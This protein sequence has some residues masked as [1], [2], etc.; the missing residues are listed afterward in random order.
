MTD[1]RRHLVTLA[2]IQ[3]REVSWLQHGTIPR[4]MLAILAGH[5]GLGKSLWTLRLAAEL[6]HRGMNIVICSAED[7][8]EH[9]I[10]PRLQAAAADTTKV[11][12]LIPRDENGDAR[13]VGFPT[14]APLLLEAILAVEAVL[15]II[16]PVTAHID[17]DVDSHKD[18]SL[19]GALAPLSRIAEESFAAV[20]A[21][22]HLNKTSSSSDP[23]M[24]V[25]GSIG[26]PGAARSAL[27]I[28]RD[29]DDPD[30]DRGSRRVL[31][32]FKC[33]V[34][35]LQ[36]SR[37]LEVVPVLL[38][39]SDGEPEVH[40]AT[41]HDLGESTHGAHSILAAGSDDRTILD[42]AIDFLT[43]ELADDDA[44]AKKLR[45]AA[46]AV[47]I[48]DR[49]LD[50]ARK[51]LAVEAYR[52]GGFGELGKWYW[53]LPTKDATL[54]VLSQNGSKDA[55]PQSGIADPRL[56]RARAGES[57]FVAALDTS[58][59][60]KPLEQEDSSKD[61]NGHCDMASLEGRFDNAERHN[62][63]RTPTANP[64]ARAHDAPARE[65]TADPYVPNPDEDLP[66]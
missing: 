16:D 42:D 52:S 15:C 62:L 65:D 61:A 25:G 39:A 40:T 18:A 49:T 6:T 48:S 34:G 30:K 31:A 20:L 36:P 63:L 13:G 51:R 66:F 19:R 56:A 9:S 59:T 17:H 28:D 57:H 37:L 41:I 1:A 32:H 21:V 58:N 47:G 22:Y 26:G 24:R 23:M 44:E 33:N 35:P 46:R 45:S 10:K 29:P 50:R 3:R 54:G 7:S 55:T 43:A 38:P 5:P 2:T 53:R 4:G 64:P 8:L 14:D 11:H 12:A 27:L 60:Q